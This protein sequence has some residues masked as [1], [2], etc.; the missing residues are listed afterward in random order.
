MGKTGLIFAAFCAA[1]LA[2]CAA[3]ENSREVTAEEAVNISGSADAI[4]PADDYAYLLGAS[5]AEALA[6]NLPEPYRVYGVNDIITMD[7]VAH[8]LNVVIGENEIVVEVKCG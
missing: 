2:G 5:R 4:C 6:A 3:P 1:A 7:Y 8:R